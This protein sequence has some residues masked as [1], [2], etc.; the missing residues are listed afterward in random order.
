MQPISLLPE[1]QVAYHPIKVSDRKKVCSSNCVYDVIMQLWN[2]DTILLYEEFLTIYTDRKNGI[3]G[4]RNFTR[5]SNC[6]T[7]VDIKLIYAVALAISASSLILCHNHPSGNLKPSQ[8]DIEITNKIKN[9]GEFLEIKL[10]DHLI[11]SDV[12]YFSFMDE[13]LI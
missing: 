11:V 13:G 7:I 4:Y 5:G 3:I 2:H 12:G 8:A 1:I 6:G 9:S 10:L